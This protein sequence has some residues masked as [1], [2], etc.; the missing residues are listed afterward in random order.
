MDQASQS[1][2]AGKDENDRRDRAMQFPDVVAQSFVVGVKRRNRKQAEEIIA[3]HID[4]ED[5]DEHHGD[6]K[7]V[8]R[9]MHRFRQGL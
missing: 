4:E 5:A 2:E 9:V 7:C 3:T 8:E 1:V 6:Q